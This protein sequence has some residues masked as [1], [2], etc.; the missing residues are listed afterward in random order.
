MNQT[1][2]TLFK[3]FLGINHLLFLLFLIILFSLFLLLR[4]VLGVILLLTSSCGVLLSY[5]LRCTCILTSAFMTGISAFLE[6]HL[7]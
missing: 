3:L 5:F 4:L 7:D 6:E 2:L 1:K